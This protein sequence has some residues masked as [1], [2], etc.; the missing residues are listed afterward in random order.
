MNTYKK[1]I[2]ATLVAASLC[3][4]GGSGG[5]DTPTPVANQIP[6][7]SVSN[8]SAAEVSAVTVSATAAD[9]D[10]SIVSYSWVQKAGPQVILS[11]VTSA[12]VSFTA[13]AVTENQDLVFTVTVTDDKGASATKD[14]TVTV[15]AN[16][17]MFTISGKVTDNPVAD[18]KVTVEVAGQKVEVVADTDGNYSADVSVDDSFANALV[19]ITAVG[20]EANSKT[21]LISLLGDVSGLLES[22]GD[23]MVLTKDEAFAV[24]VTNVTTAIHALMKQ[25]NG[26]EPLD[27]KES[28]DAAQ[29]NYDAGLVLSLATAIKLVLDYATDYPEL[30][31]PDGI[32]DVAELVDDLTRVSS[33][34]NNAFQAQEGVYFEA[35]EA[36]VED[37]EVLASSPTSS[38]AGTYYF[39][40]TEGNLAAD[41]IV[42]FA[43]GSGE[44]YGVSN[45]SS[46]SWTDTDEGTLI[47]Y[48]GKGM[49]MRDWYANVNSSQVHYER[50]RT[51][52]LIKWISNTD[53]SAQMVIGHDEL[54]IIPETGVEEAVHE[55]LSVS[56]S[57]IK[58]AGLIEPTEV[59]KAG[60]TY[61]VPVP[62]LS[63]PVENLHDDASDSVENTIKLTIGQTNSATL[64]RQRYSNDGTSSYFDIA[65]TYSVTDAG[66]LKVIPAD[67]SAPSLD[68]ALYST[69]NINKANVLTTSSRSGGGYLL[70]KGSTQWVIA[71]IPGIYD[72]GWSF[73][74]PLQYF[75]I[76]L[77]EDGRALTVSTYDWF[78]D[79]QLDEDDIS[80]MP[81]LWML[82]NSGDLVIR[83]YRANRDISSGGFCEPQ[84]WEPTFNDPCVLY[85][86]RRWELH[87]VIGNRYYLNNGHK[88]FLD[89]Y[90]LDLLGE[91][92]VDKHVLNYASDGN[93]SWLK[94]G[95]RPISLPNQAVSQQVPQKLKPMKVSSPWS[96][97]HKQAEAVEPDLLNAD[98]LDL[99]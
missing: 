24:N 93:R 84:Q 92:P 46:F 86:E 54:T 61:S 90:G 65:A 38:I 76:E 43:N 69:E 72:L 3:A 75:W 5:S 33:Y 74:D 71:D 95:A 78:S 81:G 51:S 48:P 82:D 23:D 2:L 8:L 47:T 41:R 35:I 79:G 68:I 29:Q 14:V 62:L 28:F 11:G 4:C 20:P 63:S 50:Y 9:A 91:I 67:S 89:Y 98:T 22:A 87:S 30:V 17:L 42:F 73:F 83:R 99:R 77:Y 94:V 44:F 97:G 18:A 88:F 56:K 70:E 45:A 85:H 80:I 36:I 27:S 31:L 32:S 1:S 7:V 57:A 12:A 25:A 16:M 59:I 49:F 53:A 66:T 19:R 21:K 40:S 10:G 55:V 15:T 39:T 64:T 26:G 6:T 58:K 13:P 34:L 52:T 37:N 96:W 60:A